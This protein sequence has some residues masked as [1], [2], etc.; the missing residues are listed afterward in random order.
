MCLNKNG[1]HF[2]DGYVVAGSCGVRTAGLANEGMIGTR[3]LAIVAFVA[4][5]AK[6]IA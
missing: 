3:E 1:E 4:I 5:V 6:Q 2:L